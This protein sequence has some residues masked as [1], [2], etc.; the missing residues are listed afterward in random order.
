MAWND[1]RQDV[2]PLNKTNLGKIL[3]PAGLLA[4]LVPQV[5]SAMGLILGVGIA[6]LVGNPFIDR[7]R[8]MTK[9]LLAWS[10]IGL[11]AGVNLAVVLSAGLNGIVF[12]LISLTAALMVG[13]WIG[14]LLK[15]DAETSILI[16]VG[17]A[18][19]GG[20]AIAAV[21]SAINAK[22]ES[23]SV[24]MGIVFIL[25]AVALLIFP[26]I[27][28]WFHLSESQFG[29]WAALAIHDTSSVVG[30]S[31]QFGPH[32]L[33]VGTTVKLVRALWIIPVTLL[34]AKIYA[35]K[36]GAQK[37]APSQ[38]PWFIGGFVMMS[39]LVTWAPALQPAGHQ[40]EWIARRALVLTL[41]LIGSGLTISTLK[42][43]GFKSIVH[44]VTLWL[45]I[46][47][48]SLAFIYFSA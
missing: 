24:S 36:D 18:I 34:F 40:V 31:M 28:Q 41:F 21:S 13:H 32:A 6:L 35:K 39:A 43:V 38:K 15:N 8:K 7:T 4:C 16:N 33:E 14:R 46:A 5:T 25:N 45:A 9:P 17:T 10:I 12:T 1:E 26:T 20:S 44:G 23:I 48:T 11:G 42:K 3:I 29:L 37:S 30:A 22:N 47:T 27:G 2:T 19:C